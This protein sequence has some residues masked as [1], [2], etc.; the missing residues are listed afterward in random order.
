M[1][2]EGE[3][4]RRPACANNAQRKQDSGKKKILSSVGKFDQ[5]NP[6]KSI[7]T[8]LQKELCHQQTEKSVFT[9]Y[10]NLTITILS[11]LR[12]N[13]IKYSCMFLPLC[14]LLC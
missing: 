10:T 14:F 7:V 13:V 3:A 8:L 5:K 6:P 4:A 11:L 12:L 2:G 9:A 1:H